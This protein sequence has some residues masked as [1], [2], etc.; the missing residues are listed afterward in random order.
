MAPCEYTGGERQLK[1][2]VFWDELLFIVYKVAHFIKNNKLHRRCI[3]L[4]VC[5]KQ[6]FVLWKGFSWRIRS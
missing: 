2:E 3:E 5:E 1:L 4:E 6:V